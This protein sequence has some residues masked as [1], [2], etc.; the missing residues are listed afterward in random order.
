MVA[1][2]LLGLW[3]DVKWEVFCGHKSAAVGMLWAGGHWRENDSTRQEEGGKEP[4]CGGWEEAKDYFPPTRAASL[5]A[6]P[7][8]SD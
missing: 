3:Q 1:V 7:R 4:G 6:S 2:A 8:V 5:F